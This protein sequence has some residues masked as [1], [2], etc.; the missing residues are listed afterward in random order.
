MNDD[1]DLSNFE[2][3]A[4]KTKKQL[5][6]S[7]ETSVEWLQLAVDASAEQL[8]KAG[9]FSREEG[10]RARQF[11]K[12]DLAATRVDFA[13]AREAVGRGLS[14]SRISGGFADL[15]SH[16]FA[17]MGDLFEG[18]AAKSEDS[19]AFKTGEI[20][21]PGTLTCTDCG[22]ELRLTKS[23]RIPP[24]AKCHKTEFRKSY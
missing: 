3:L 2:K 22:N 10:E 5:I 20:C 12:R 21:G 1:R 18:W 15:A 9:E 17:S 14:P 6:A 11:L 7:K 24:C 4:A 13:S 8:E 16:L 23:S 19:L